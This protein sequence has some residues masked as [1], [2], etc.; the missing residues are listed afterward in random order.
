MNIHIV[1]ALVHKAMLGRRFIQPLFLTPRYK[2]SIGVCPKHSASYQS[3]SE[4]D[5]ALK[6]LVV[7][8]IHGKQEI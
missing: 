2:K 8:S 7:R 6:M 3:W 5:I 4:A 1:Q